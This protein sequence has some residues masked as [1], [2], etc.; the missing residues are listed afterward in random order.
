MKR[1]VRLGIWIGLLI[2]PVVHADP[3]LTAVPTLFYGLPGE[4]VGWGFEVINDTTNYL[5][6]DSSAFCQIAQDPQYTTCTQTLGT[7]NDLIANNA[8][9]VAPLTTLIQP[10]DPTQNPALGLGTYNIIA[11]AMRSEERRV[12]KECR[13]RWSPYH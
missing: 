1:I 10:Y 9:E 4:T 8:T 13:S 5:L 12:G 7:Y 11:S 6:F 2:C 3:I